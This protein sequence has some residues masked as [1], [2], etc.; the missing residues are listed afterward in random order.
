MAL[1]FSCI[2]GFLGVGVIAWYGFA[3]ITGE[4]YVGAE[5]R[6]QES[7]VRQVEPAPEAEP[8]I[9]SS[10]GGATRT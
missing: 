7:E 10:G 3:E 5:K 2:A 8:V 1:V 6:I 9:V 4:T